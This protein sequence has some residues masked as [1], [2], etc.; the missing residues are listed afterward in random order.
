MV[1]AD[2]DIIVDPAVTS[3]EGLYLADGVFRTGTNGG[4]DQQL[5]VRGGVIGY[6][7][8][9][10]GIPADGIEFQRNLQGG[11]STLPAEEFTYAPDQMLR[12]PPFLGN[13]TIRWLEVNP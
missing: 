9:G 10:V 7:D 4:T 8:V 6:G 3:L 11:N 1:I 5:K 13:R 12:F 2:N